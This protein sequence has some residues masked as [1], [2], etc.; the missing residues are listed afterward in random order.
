MPMKAPLRIANACAFWG[1]QPGAAATLVSAQPDVDFLTLDYL[2]EVSLSIMAIARDR[3]PGCGYAKDFVEA[4]RS[5]CPHWAAG[6]RTRV[7][8]NAGGLDPEACARACA[9]VLR[10]SVPRPMRVAVVAGDD[11]VDLLRSAPG[12]FANAETGEPLTPVAPRLVA[13]NAY[14]GHERIA[15]A[16]R[17]GADIVVTGRV[18]DPS[19]TVGPCAA[20]FGWSAS[21]YDRL[22]VATVAGHVIEC[23][24]QACGGFSTDWLDVPGNDSIG[25]P[26]AEVS[27][28]GGFVVTK[29][30][31]TGGAVTVQGVKE[32]LLY[33][34]GD[35]GSYLSPDVTASF[36]TLRVEQAGAD[37]VRV[38]GATGRA[39]TD[40]YKVSAAYR[41]GYR[42]HGLVTVFGHDAVRKARQAGSGL[43]QRLE[44]SGCVFREHLIECLGTGACVRGI[45]SRMSDTHLVE[46][47]L[48]VSVAADERAPVERFSREVASLVTAG[49]QG[50]TGYTGGRPKVLPVLAYWPT[51][52]A[53]SE[54][55]PS[56]RILETG[57]P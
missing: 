7:V 54:V 46:T 4:V 55:K 3:E 17:A 8:T 25:F 35:P 16:L 41:D 12:G 45:A 52:V 49:P 9:D 48:R 10:S 37:R 2:A 23:G 5:L 33:E 32:Q 18:A 50:V 40:A 21:D 15:E 26:V 11:V 29:P 30:P 57:R 43:L 22:A 44:R 38:S 24:A 56:L 20:H 51:L 34:V 14:L 19:L 47:V 13:A 28:D 27:A 6:G 42:A 31:G 1:D 39:P 36:L 53:K